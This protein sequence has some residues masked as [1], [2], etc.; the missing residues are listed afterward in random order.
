MSDHLAPCLMIATSMN[1]LGGFLK[2]YAGSNYTL[3][4]IGQCC[5]GFALAGQLQVPPGNKF[6]LFGFFYWACCYSD[7]WTVVRSPWT[8][9]GTRSRYIRSLRWMALWIHLACL[10]YGYLFSW[11]NSTWST[12]QLT[13]YNQTAFS[14]MYLHQMIILAIPTVVLAFSVRSKP[15]N[16]PNVGAVR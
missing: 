14:K 12:H 5:C 2:W 4:I 6:T 1:T 15:V 16:P 13:Q 10:L 7:R 11:R 9:L 3:A 8:L